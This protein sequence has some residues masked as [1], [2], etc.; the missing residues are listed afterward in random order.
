MLPEKHSR[1]SLRPISIEHEFDCCVI[2]VGRL[3][4]CFAL[5][6]ERVGLRVIGV[7]VNDAYVKSIAEKTLKSDEPGLSECLLQSERFLV[8]TDFEFAVQSARIVFVLVATP[9]DGGKHYYDHGALSNLLVRLNSKRLRSVDIVINSTVYPGYIRNIGSLLL[10]DC[11]DV[12][13]SY[14]PAFVAQGDVMSGYRTGGWF[15]MVLIGA[16]TARVAQLLVDIYERFSE[17]LEKSSNI[18]VMSPESAEICKLASNCFRTTKISFANMIGDIADRTVGANK[19]D[20]CDAL[21]SDRSIGPI[22]MTPGYGFGGPCY[23][24]DNK[25][26]A[27][28][29]RQCGI[30]PLI[31][32]ATDDYNDVHHRLMVQAIE[33]TQR[34]VDEEIVFSDVTYK[35]N[36]AV[37]IIVS[38]PKLEVA[39]ELARKGRRVKIV[40][41]YEVILEVMK[42]YGNLFAYETRE[43]I[44]AAEY[45][46]T[47]LQDSRSVY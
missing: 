41:R 28:Y 42:E 33:Q 20:I 19:H 25:A 39:R 29:A 24:R 23:P 38:S 12:T 16:A 9:T 15:G 47:D 2:G 31:P 44:H 6:L 21:K 30:E 4:L 27:M 5:T 11:V 7:D 13:L 34:L 46:K 8:T 45:F 3:G 10:A 40:D 43:A 22:C 26:L 18:C 35:P 32:V 36:C 37:P 14:N 17:G 1:L